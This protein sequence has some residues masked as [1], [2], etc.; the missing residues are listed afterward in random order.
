M[1]T[2]GRAG[3][4]V[5]FGDITPKGGVE[6]KRMIEGAFGSVVQGPTQGLTEGAVTSKPEQAFI[7]EGWK[8][9]VPQ[10]TLVGGGSLADSA[11]VDGMKRI[12]EKVE[13]QVSE[14]EPQTK[15]PKFQ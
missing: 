15:K 6:G 2:V 8:V 3:G 1:G 14:T 12:S 13:Q 10:L 11:V 5:Q 7:K 4:E 9:L